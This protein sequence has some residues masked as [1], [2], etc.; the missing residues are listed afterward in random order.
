MVCIRTVHRD[1]N[2]YLSVVGHVQV[3]AQDSACLVA[4]AARVRCLG[5]SS[6]C[7]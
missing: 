1:L 2:G 5:E 6:E 4:R 7:K 3:V